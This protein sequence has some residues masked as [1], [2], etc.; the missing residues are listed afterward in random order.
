MKA[1]TR[2]WR[3]IVLCAGIF[4]GISSQ[5]HARNLADIVKARSI[6][7]GILTDVPSLNQASGNKRIGFEVAL[8][9]KFAKSLKISV[10]WVKTDSKSIKNDLTSNK[11][12][13][14]LPQRELL[15]SPLPSGISNSAPYYCSGAVILTRDTA[16][17]NS[18]GLLDKKIAIQPGKSYFDYLKRLSLEKNANVGRDVNTTILDLIYKNADVVIVDKLAALQAIGVYPKANLKMSHLLWAT[19]FNALVNSKDTTLVEA[20]N[21]F[22]KKIVDTGE[23]EQLSQPYFAESVRCSGY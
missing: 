6:K 8:M 9:D 11:I 21:R 4:G 15:S 20:F 23:Y 18:S 12:D 5:A 10:V 7:V 3:L 13:L 22:I 2:R 19:Q 1:L 17:K 14:L 16:I